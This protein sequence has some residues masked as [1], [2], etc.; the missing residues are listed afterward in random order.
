[1]QALHHELKPIFYKL[2]SFALSLH[3][4]QYFLLQGE[5]KIRKVNCKSRSWI[6]P[7]LPTINY[8]VSFYR[9]CK[10]PLHQSYISSTD[11][12]CI[13]LALENFL[14]SHRSTIATCSRL[15]Q[16]VSPYHQI[17]QNIKYRIERR[18]DGKIHTKI[19]PCVT[20]F[21]KSIIKVEE[22]ESKFE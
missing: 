3:Y 17:L 6:Q 5:K 21:V 16:T 4:R 15:Y 13:E 18:A 9:S 8:P 22:K 11:Q 7:L 1:M 10:V 2:E 19:L 12:L 14:S 20:S